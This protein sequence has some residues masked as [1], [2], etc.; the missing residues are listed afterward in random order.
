[1][2]KEDKNMNEQMKDLFQFIFKNVD[3]SKIS[4]KNKEKIKTEIS[5]LQSFVVGARAARIAIVGRR[6][7]GK[8]SLINAIFGELKA[9][10]GDYTSQ[11]GSGNWY[12]FENELGGIDILDTRGLGESQHPQEVTHANS[13]IEEVKLAVDDK[14]PD[15]ILF[16]CKGKEV[17]ARLDEDIAQL[18][19]L[20]S[21]IK[22]AHEYDVPVVGIVTQV[23]ELA[24]VSNSEAPFEHPKK[25]ENIQATVQLLEE[26]I[27]EVMP[28]P[29]HVIP[30]S[31][32]MEFT[33]DGQIEYDRRW[34]VD[35]LLDYLLTELPN[36]A[37]V[38]L[39]KLSKVKS[40]QKRLARKIGKSVMTVTGLVGAT[41]VPMADLPII[42]G[43]QVSMI[44]TIAMIS[45][46]KLSKKTIIEFLGAMGINIGVGVALRG[47][48]RQ[49]VKVLPVAGSV[50]AGSIASAGTYALCEAAIAYFIDHKSTEEA[51][52]I[53]E[54]QI[55]R[56]KE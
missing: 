21:D 22:Q 11:T 48:S 16:L 3:K 56:V 27:A 13:P 17:G 35:V 52:H 44:G 6:G 54:E 18:K 37:Q 38:I 26:K 42:T 7:A 46:K 14:C 15:V 12:L 47:I 2:V 8:S 20:K 55:E 45:G 49:L 36:E 24:P 1:M 31:A 32:Y 41:P 53:F 4:G 34:N 40:V 25:Q 5:G 33:E 50:I 43:L 9:E 29:I 28:G 39:A 10:V 30:V 19:Q 23:D 51:K